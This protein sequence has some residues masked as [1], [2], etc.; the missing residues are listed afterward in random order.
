[1]NAPGTAGQRQASTTSHRSAPLHTTNN[2]CAIH[3]YMCRHIELQR[4]RLA[5][6]N[7]DRLCCVLG[8]LAGIGVRHHFHQIRS[9]RTGRCQLVKP[10]LVHVKLQMVAAQ[11]RLTNL[12]S[13]QHVQQL[14]STECEANESTECEAMKVNK[15]TNINLPGELSGHTLQ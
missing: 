3:A 10:L 2:G 9:T 6:D 11:N 7:Q 13:A 5:V 4:L 1:M 14:N 15:L 12:A 8:W